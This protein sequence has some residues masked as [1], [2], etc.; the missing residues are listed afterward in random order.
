[1]KITRLLLCLV[2]LSLLSAVSLAD[3]GSI[4]NLIEN[5]DAEYALDESVPILEVVFPRVYSSD[6]TIIRFGDE[7][8]LVDA[9]TDS[10][11]MHERIRAAIEAMGI[12]HFDIAYN[13]HPHRDHILG[14]P[15]IHDYAPLE[16]FFVTFPEDSDVNLK[17]IMRIMK[18]KEVP[19]ELLGHGDRLQLGEESSLV[20]DI[21]QRRDNEYWSLNDRS[22]MLH[23]T[24]GDRTMLLTGDNGARSQLYFCENLPSSS[25]KA[26][27]MKYPHHGLSALSREFKE[28]VSPELCILTG[29]VNTSDE[30]KKYLTKQQI[31]Y[32]IAYQGITRMRTDGNIWVID[33]LE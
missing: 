1:M 19:I 32:L 15:I 30:S 27:I 26:D 18:E 8:L 17:K 16:K 33:Y 10:P 3:S 23:I 12:D 24:Y 20:I 5:P 31:P 22:A 7:T 9:S 25:L 14:F 2:V 13:S 11:T 29:A 6:C 4:V 28:A 21:I